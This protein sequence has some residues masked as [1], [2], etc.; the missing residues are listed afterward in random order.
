MFGLTLD[1]FKCLF[2]HKNLHTKMLYINMVKMMTHSDLHEYSV[3][4][5]WEITSSVINADL[6]VYSPFP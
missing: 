5:F 2:K 1:I 6:W 3:V 4:T